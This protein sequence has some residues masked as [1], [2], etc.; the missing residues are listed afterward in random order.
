VVLGASATG[1]GRLLLHYQQW[2]ERVGG[3]LVVIFGLYTLGVL[4]SACFFARDARAARRQP[5]GFL[6]SVLAGAAFGAGWTPC[7]G[8]SSARSCCTPARRPTWERESRCSSPTR[9]GS[10]LPFLAAAAA[11]EGFLRWFQRFRRYIGWVERV[12][13]ALLIVAAFMMMFGWFTLLSAWLQGLYTRVLK[14]R[15]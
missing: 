13:G 3:A 4:R 11:L 9:S 2:I 7:I 14:S 15:L 12:A 1:L 10:R 8:R 6:G 5:V